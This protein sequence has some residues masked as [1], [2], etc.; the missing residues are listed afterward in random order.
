MSKTMKQFLFWTPRI[1]GIVFAAFISIFAL[2]VFDQ[3]YTFW[4]TVV[5]L[6]MNLIPTLAILIALAIA[7][8]WEWVGGILFIALGIFYIISKWGMF[9]WS[10]YVLIAGPAFLVAALFLVDWFY[11]GEIKGKPGN[12]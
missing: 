10:V 4:E 12:P 6:L 1:L 7:W 3:G 9:P 11:R 2:D 8:R 5:A